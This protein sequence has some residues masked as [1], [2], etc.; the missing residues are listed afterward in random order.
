MEEYIMT[1]IRQQWKALAAERKITRGDIAALILYRTLVK[2][3]GKEAAIAKLR[4]SFIPIANPIKLQNGAYPYGALESAL[5]SVKYSTVFTWLQEDEKEKLVA[6][7]KEIKI[8]GSEI[9]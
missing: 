4:K 9:L 6:L 8:K 2:G 3:Q 1:D 7:A 5:W